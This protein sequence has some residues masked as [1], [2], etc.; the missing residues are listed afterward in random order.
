MTGE[1]EGSRLWSWFSCGAAIMVTLAVG[2]SLGPRASWAP[3]TLWRSIIRV[4]FPLEP[5]GS[6]PKVLLCYLRSGAKLRTRCREDAAR[7][8]AKRESTAKVI[9]SYDVER[10]PAASMG[11]GSLRKSR[12]GSRPRRLCVLECGSVRAR[13]TENSEG[14]SW[15]RRRG[16]ND[17]IC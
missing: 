1:L 14:R 10:I 16:G 3:P 4:V 9:R 6:L 15:T 2:Y 11:I 7:Y 8:L 17:P 13:R 5:A 12:L